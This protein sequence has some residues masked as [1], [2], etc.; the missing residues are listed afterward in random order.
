MKIL[1]E[2][3]GLLPDD[4]DCG[5]EFEIEVSPEIPAKTYGPPESCYPAEGGEVDPTECPKCG[6]E[7]DVERALETAHDYD[8][9][10]REDAEEAR[11][12]DRRL[13]L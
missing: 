7:V 4:S 2:C 5:H 12:E 9:A 13:G 11:E 10:A 6:K 3:L 1:Y 8:Q